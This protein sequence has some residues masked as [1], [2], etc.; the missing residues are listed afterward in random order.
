[1]VHR[2][3]AI[4]ATI[5]LS[6]LILIPHYEATAAAT[7]TIKTGD[8]V[9]IQFTCRF[10]DGKIAAGTSSA[11]SK[12]QSLQ[13]S[14]VFL[15][16]SK[17]TPIE[18]TAGKTYG[19]QHFPLAFE[20]EIIS[21]IAQALVG[22]KTGEKQSIEIRSQ[23]PANVPRKDQFL[24]LARIRTRPLE[25]KMTPAEYKTRFKKEPKVGAPYPMDPLIPYKV[26]S[27][28]KD[29]VVVRP[30]VKPGQTIET[31]FGKGTF[32]VNGNQLELVIDA[33]KGN[34]VRMGI[35]VGRIL[36]VSEKMFTMDFGNPFGGEPLLCEVKA[37]RVPGKKPAAKGK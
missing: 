28:S 37:E 32:R 35:N 15:P 6:G 36:D 13:K 2:S 29:I 24:Q 27:V 17:D 19:P 12:E 26:E 16:R 23:A 31:G 22:M 3:K 11:V 20:T 10:P 5:L 8:K 1:M 4:F 33:K 30:S 34:L 21:R 9:S 18:V 7:E 14:P 25:I